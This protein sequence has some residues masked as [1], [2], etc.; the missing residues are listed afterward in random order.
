MITPN[1]PLRRSIVELIRTG[2]SPHVASA[3][4]MVEILNSIFTV[5]DIEKIRA[6]ARDRDRFV[7]SKGHGAGG[8]YV[9][10][11]K[12]GLM[13]DAQLSSFHQNGSLLAGHASHFVKYVEHSTGAL[14]HGLSPALG[15]AIGLRSLKSASKVFVLVGDGEL[16]EGSNWEALMLAGHLGLTNLSVLIDNNGYDQMGALSACCDIEPLRAKFESFN[17]EVAEVDGHSEDEIIGVLK[18]S[19]NKKPIAIICHTT[20]GKGVSFMEG[21]TV[22]HYRTPVGEEYEKALAELKD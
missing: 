22:W 15:M 5:M 2:G 4:S 7:M 1:R 19:G 18:K 20:K 6:G 14:G 11:R 8:L 10:M 17:F 16:H 13:T 12:H 9:I 21:N 3:L